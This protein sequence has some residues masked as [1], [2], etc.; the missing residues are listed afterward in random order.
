MTPLKIPRYPVSNKTTPDRVTEYRF[1]P[2]DQYKGEACVSITRSIQMTYQPR[3]NTETTFTVSNDHW[4]AFSK[5]I[6]EEVIPSSKTTSSP[7]SLP[8]P[9]GAVTFTFNLDE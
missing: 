5:W 3:Y 6:K 1:T 2:K 8:S 9:N 4:S 7:L